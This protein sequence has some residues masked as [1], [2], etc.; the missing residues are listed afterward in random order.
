MSPTNAPVESPATSTPIESPS[1]TDVPSSSSSPEPTRG[2]GSISPSP[3]VTVPDW[4]NNSTLNDTTTDGNAN[5]T[6]VCAD[7]NAASD[8][9]HMLVQERVCDTL[10]GGVDG[11]PVVPTTVLCGKD[12]SAADALD[13]T[14]GNFT[15]LTLYEDSVTGTLAG[16]S[17]ALDGSSTSQL[18]GM[19]DGTEFGVYNSGTMDLSSPIIRLRA[20]VRYAPDNSTSSGARRLLRVLRS[21]LLGSTDADASAAGI[22]GLQMS[23]KNTQLNWGMQTGSSRVRRFDLNIGNGTLA[24]VS[25]FAG[26]TGES[27]MRQISTY[28]CKL[29]SGYHATEQFALSVCTPCSIITLCGMPAENHFPMQYSQRPQRQPI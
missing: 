13:V 15:S 29:V 18:Y 6:W 27:G 8:G 10:M 12:C 3:S 2:G 5:D 20:W 4:L 23:T 24:G 26:T 11:C 9:R 17:F 7:A 28:H 19:D 25:Y 21:M 16:V 1:P 22:V 14:L